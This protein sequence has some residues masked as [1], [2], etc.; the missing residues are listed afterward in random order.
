MLKE[1]ESFT[2]T[3]YQ[4]CIKWSGSKR[5]QAKEILKYFPKEINTYWEP[6]CGGAS[7]FYTL[8][9]SEIKVK[10]FVLSDSNPHLMNLWQT[11]KNNPELVSATY[12]DLWH[13]M[14]EKETVQEKQEFYNSVRNDF[15]QTHDSC[16][17]MFLMRTCYNGMPR[18]NKNGEFNTPYHLNRDGVEPPTIDRI[19]Y[20]WYMVFRLSCAT[21]ECCDYKDITPRPGDF[22]YLDP[23]YNNTKGMY[24]GGIDNVELF[25]WLREQNCEWAL[26]YNGKSGNTDYTFPVPKD[27]YTN[28][29]YLDSGN[30]SFKR[31][32]QTDKNAMVRES[33]YIRSTI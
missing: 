25:E 28:H 32:V 21:L 3:V 22:V 11:V 14:K 5:S 19:I 13:K 12:S 17:F 9:N 31:L 24:M 18:F 2:T 1:I 33:L 23:P 20:D 15:N 26:S 4:P 27:I 16:K 6:F 7:V 30:S 8:F 10:R 29:V